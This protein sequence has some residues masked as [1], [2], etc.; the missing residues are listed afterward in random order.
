[1]YYLAFNSGA[2]S[3]A[4]LVE[5]SSYGMVSGSF[6]VTGTSADGGTTGSI[7][8]TR[9][10]PGAVTLYE[11]EDTFIGTFDELTGVCVIHE[12]FDQTSNSVTVN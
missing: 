7:S 3:V 1:M 11:Y 9:I 2:T 5:S 10:A 6:I 8:F 12:G 4:A